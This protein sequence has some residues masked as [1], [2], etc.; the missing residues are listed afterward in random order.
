MPLVN[1]LAFVLAAALVILTPGPATLLVASAAQRSRRAASACVSGIVL[2][3]LVLIS[4]SAIGVGM[5]FTKSPQLARGLTLVGAMYI[6]WLGVNIVRSAGRP[7]AAAAGRGGKRD[8]LGALLLT[9]SNPKPVIFFAA[10]FPLFIEPTAWSV[11]YLTCTA[12]FE[13]INLAYFAVLVGGIRR[14]GNSAG[15]GRTAAAVWMNRAC[16]G[17]LIGCGLVSAWRALAVP[18]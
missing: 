2:G 10:F 7:S 9:L 3:D 4:L 12:L 18:G 16:G 14:W 5:L 15:A 6:A 11:G 13:S 8:F 1:P 17:V